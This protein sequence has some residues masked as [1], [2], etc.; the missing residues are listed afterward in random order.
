MIIFDT[1]DPAI[2]GFPIREDHVFALKVQVRD[3]ESGLMAFLGESIAV[4]PTGAIRMSNQ[5]LGLTVID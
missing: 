1:T 4:G 3:P 5:P 2:I